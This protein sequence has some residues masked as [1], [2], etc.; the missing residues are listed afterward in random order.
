VF[1]T[2][3][4]F[5][6]TDTPNGS[7]LGLEKA[8]SKDFNPAVAGT[9][10]SIFYQK[11]DA[12]TG[13]DD[14]ETG[15]PSVGQA[16]I[17]VSDEGAVKITNGKGVVVVQAQLIPVADA[18]YLYGSAGELADPC[19]GLFT[20]RV[21]TATSQEDVFVTFIENAM[22]FSSF[23]ANLPWNS[24]TGTYNYRYGVGLKQ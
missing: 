21:I 6:V 9:Y 19:D 11:M 17:V 14:V 2:S 10:D 7:I 23:S 1:G 22:L 8:A 18:N 20:F 15:K 5:F 24:Q 12:Q 4:G 16:T 13:Q 3:G